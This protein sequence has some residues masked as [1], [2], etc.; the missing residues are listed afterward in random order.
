[1]DARARA[2]Q[3]L[4]YVA[5]EDWYFLSHCLPMARAARAA[6]FEVHVAA[7]VTEDAANIRGEGFILHTVRFSRG[8]S[9]PL[10]TLR[11]ISTLRDL[12]RAVDPAIV[13]H[14]A[15]E[16]VLLGIA[17]SFGSAF[18]AVYAT[19]GLE[20][21]PSR[22]P[23]AGEGKSKYPSPLAGEGRE[24]R[25]PS[26]KRRLLRPGRR[27]LLRLGLKRRRAVGLVQT[28]DDREVLTRLGVKPDRIVLIPG[29]GIDADRLRPIPEPD[30]PVTV[31][32]AGRMAAGNGVRTLIEAQ[33]ILRASGIQ[34]DLL[35]AGTPD[36]ADL[37]SMPQIEIA[38][39]GRESGI[40]WLG[41]VADIAAVWRRAHI[42]VLPSRGTEGVP[43]G[44]LEAAAFGRPLIATDVPGCREIVIHEKTGLLVPVDDPQALASAILRLVRS[45]S[46]RVRFGVAAR[47]LVDERFAADLI[48]QATV[49][50]YQRLLAS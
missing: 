42:A 48:G 21:P 4:I 26:A 28:P 38:G 6:G 22:P 49:A 14:V 43:K 45:S 36:L 31:A 47:R 29:C 40:T 1:M 50:L 5:T 15:M 16:P 11:T 27:V 8:R 25:T 33:R 18:A 41:H 17:A 9:A 13:H 34:S 32:F 46:Q 10:R 3:R 7:N 20:P 19:T 23:P 35:L 39:W 44:L 12:Y 2:V 30:G 37:T 24:G